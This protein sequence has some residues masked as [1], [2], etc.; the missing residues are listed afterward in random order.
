MWY[1]T[2]HHPIKFLLLVVL[3]LEYA[4]LS[5]PF[6]EVGPLLQL[7]YADVIRPWRQWHQPRDHIQM[8]RVGTKCSGLYRRRE[9]G[10][11]GL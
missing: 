7:I 10:R 3:I 4:T 1:F 5:I 11:G 8:W 9:I 2:L 6:G